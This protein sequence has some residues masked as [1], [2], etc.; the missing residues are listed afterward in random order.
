M[1]AR[2]PSAIKASNTPFDPVDIA[3][4][5]ERIVCKKGSRK[6]TDFYC[7]GVYGGI[8]TA[9][10]VGCNLRC[11]FC[12]VNWGR[13][14][15]H[16]TGQLY[17]SQDVFN[18]LV[19]NA[20]KK[21]IKKLR[22]SGGEPT[23]CFDHLKAVLDLVNKTDYLFILETNGVML[24]RNPG[25]VE[26]LKNYSNI[27][28]RVSIK[29]GHEMGF[30]R[31]T[32]ARGDCHILPFRAVEFLVESGISFHVAAMTD[33]RLM[34]K[35]ENLTMHE[36]LKYAGYSDYLEEEQCDPYPT[37]IARLKKAGYTLWKE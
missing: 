6:Y 8:S 33:P 11:V 19:H 31:R 21:K 10:A 27:H 20:Q 7:T 37:A 12:W 35:E 24:G 29:A 32:G 14:Y 13:D 5:T 1:Q 17:S 2:Y 4:I 28:I 25:W 34:S 9:Y 15:P 22:I 16:N 26:E 36:K 23:L 30:E 18:T 3:L